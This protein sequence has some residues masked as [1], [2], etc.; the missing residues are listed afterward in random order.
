M[1][2]STNL[3][4]P[5]HHVNFKNFHQYVT[6]FGGSLC[7]GVLDRNGKFHVVGDRNMMLTNLQAMA[8]TDKRR[9]MDWV[10]KDRSM[11]KLPMPLNELLLTENQNKMKQCASSIVHHFMDSTQQLGKVG[12]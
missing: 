12:I 1:Q 4:N 8:I 5:L 6:A 7:A 11:P 9:S 3:L 10:P 2:S